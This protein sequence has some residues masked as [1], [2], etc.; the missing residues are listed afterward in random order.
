MISDNNIFLRMSPSA[1][2]DKRLTDTGVPGIIYNGVPDW[3][4]QEE[5][6]PKPEA[7]WPS[8]DGSLLLYAAFNDSK[9]GNAGIQHTHC[10]RFICLF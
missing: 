10:Y 7:L 2:E 3:L 4:Y 1:P 6:L 9:V 8:P 5:V